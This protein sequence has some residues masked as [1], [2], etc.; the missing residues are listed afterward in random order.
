MRLKYRKALT[1]RERRHRRVRAKVSGTAMR[2]RLNVF[3]S[4]AHIYAQVIDDSQ[5][6][7][8][9][10]ASDLDEAV[11]EKAGEGAN[12]ASRAKAVGEV[13]A[14]RAQAAGIGS[15]VFDRGGFLYH[16][17]IKAVADGAREG[18]LKF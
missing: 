4:S 5:G 11:R 6:H 14:E 16:G 13:V 18:G 3:R 2:P 1:T 15:V 12:K 17:R 9:V 8:L 10:S 7:T